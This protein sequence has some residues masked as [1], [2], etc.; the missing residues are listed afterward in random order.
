MNKVRLLLIIL[1]LFMSLAGKGER[2]TNAGLY[3][4]EKAICS[5]YVFMNNFGEQHLIMLDDDPQSLLA[6][7]H[8]S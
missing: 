2:H 6:E 4:K 3:V 8:Y 1:L 7:T 5:I